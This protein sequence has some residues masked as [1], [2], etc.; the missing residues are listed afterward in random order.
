MPDHDH[1]PDQLTP[2][3]APPDDG[4]TG[5]HTLVVCALACWIALL[6]LVTTVFQP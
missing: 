1:R 4:W 3:A 2:E 5:L 6:W